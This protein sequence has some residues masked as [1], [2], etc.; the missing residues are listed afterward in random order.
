MVYTCLLAIVCNIGTTDRDQTYSKNV[1]YTITESGSNFRMS[2]LTRVRSKLLSERAF[3]SE[4]FR[5]HEEFFASVRNFEAK[6]NSRTIDRNLITFQKITPPDV[7]YS[8]HREH[9]LYL[10]EDTRVGSTLTFS[11]SE[12]FTD[13][14]FVPLVRIPNTDVDT[15][16][17]EFNHP[18][19]VQVDFEIFFPGD[20][21][22]YTIKRARV[23]TTI[24]FTKFERKPW[25]PY[26]PLQKIRALVLPK[27][28][29]NSKNIN[30]STP[31]EFAR[32]YFGLFQARQ[33][34]ESEF[35]QF[36]D[37][38]TA[39]A[40]DSRSKLIILHDYVRKNIRYIAFHDSLHA[41]VPHNPTDVL[42]LG[43]GDCKDRAYLIKRMAGELGINVEL[44]LLST[45][46]Q[47]RMASAHLGLFDHMICRVE[48]EG[49]TIF[50]DPTS[51][52]SEF[53]NLPSSDLS[54]MAMIL[55]TSNAQWVKISKTTAQPSLEIYIDGHID[56]LRKTDARIVVRDD[57]LIKSRLIYQQL[58]GL[59]IRNALSKL[60]SSLLFKLAFE[61]LEMTFDRETEVEF[62]G[63]C[64]M[65]AFVISSSS[66]KYVPLTAF[67]VVDADMTEREQDTL[68]F[69]VGICYN[70]RI[71]IT[72]DAPG[73]N[74]EANPIDLQGNG[75]GFESHASGSGHLDMIA[76]M[77]L[78]VPDFAD[79]TS[80]L[81]FV[82][83]YL[84]AKTQMITLSKE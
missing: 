72:L 57:F 59:E 14:S 66:K 53:G 63:R 68:P 62:R 10:P 22:P 33:I 5:V 37:S 56:S 1:T 31:Q 23:Q 60:V 48:L 7:F 39:G 6:I 8:S 13:A 83:L 19:S 82:R 42:R 49:Q 3:D 69:Y 51:K 27:I 2:A 15:I 46:P 73:Y 29:A 61:N 43:Y 47:P 35:R 38:I 17:I 21:I 20:S 4:L 76:T 40:S 34:V 26:H 41:I 65:S 32:W 12:T 84:K 44:V 11:Y 67:R 18:S 16:T 45:H 24:Q 77:D 80:F 81:D 55:D 9:R 74:V 79:K 36:V 75:V 71:A 52:Y 70:L 30:P 78:N 58:S 64:D 54:G 50:F 25:L 28:S